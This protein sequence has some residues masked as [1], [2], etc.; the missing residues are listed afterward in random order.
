MEPAT[1]L[2]DVDN[3]RSR[4]AML[5]GVLGGLGAW[6]V[7]AAQR[8]MPADASAGAPVLAGRSNSGGG[9]STELRANTTQPT[10]RAVQLGGGNGLRGEA[11]TGRGVVGIGGSQ[12]TGVWASSP[13][14][15]AVF[16]R[17]TH[18]TAVNAFALSSGSVGLAG[19]ASGSNSIA[20]IANGQSIL[21]G[22]VRITRGL[23]FD[24]MVT[25]SAPV[26]GATLFV[27]FVAGK[28]Q[29]AVR[30]TTGDVQVLA[31]QP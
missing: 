5:A 9:F 26:G 1:N 4:R 16:A 22:D 8:A 28:M 27:H 24:A 13:D 20:L 6:L 7:S 12:G 10:F 30:F 17:T 21:N 11:T 15:N 29:L 19:T 2:N 23:N 31:V 3:P 18:G 14:H 25:P